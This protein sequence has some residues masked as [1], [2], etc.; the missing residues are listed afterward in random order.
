MV[1]VLRFGSYLNGDNAKDSLF[2]VD[3]SDNNGHVT[4]ATFVK[5]FQNKRPK[6]ETM[7]RRPVRVTFPGEQVPSAADPLPAEPERL[8]TLLREG[9][10][11]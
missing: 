3:N 7:R 11:R 4:Q 6:T 5:A 1:L 8:S 9:G 2:T 10:R